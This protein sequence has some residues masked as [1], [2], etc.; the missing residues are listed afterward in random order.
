MLTIV[1]LHR[2]HGLSMSSMGKVAGGQAAS[3]GISPQEAGDF[4]ADAS[5]MFET[6]GLY[7]AANDAQQSAE[8]F[9]DMTV[10]R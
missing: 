6:M 1:D 4:M 9:W 10:P 5:I 7:Y 3:K 8:N 2:E